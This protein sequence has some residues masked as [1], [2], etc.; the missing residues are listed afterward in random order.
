LRGKKDKKAGRPGQR[1][2][3]KRGER[4]KNGSS[5]G[6][7]GFSALSRRADSISTRRNRFGSGRA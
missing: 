2:G 5:P 7:K 6:A 3:S 4:E 1:K